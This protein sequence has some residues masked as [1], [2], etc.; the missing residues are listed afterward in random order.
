MARVDAVIGYPVVGV[1]EAGALNGDGPNIDTLE[2]QNLVAMQVAAMVKQT[3]SMA[4]LG[5]SE[6][7]WPEASVC[8]AASFGF[9]ASPDSFE[10]SAEVDGAHIFGWSAEDEWTYMPG[11]YG[12]P[13]LMVPRRELKVEDVG[14]S[15]V[16]VAAETWSL[17]GIT[18]ESVLALNGLGIKLR[19]DDKTSGLQT[20]SSVRGIQQANDRDIEPMTA[21]V[22][23]K[24]ASGSYDDMWLGE[25]EST[26][27]LISAAS[28]LDQFDPNIQL[29][30]E[31]AIVDYGFEGGSS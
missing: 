24:F 19:L 3:A 16:T 2:T 26:E 23:L 8:T 21:G 22:M 27:A 12:L 7:S 11:R 31:R 18:P 5:A 25:P 1:T 30:V 14:D 28:S 9:P 29:A 10:I 20:L 15:F 17:K 6:E 4:M 13:G